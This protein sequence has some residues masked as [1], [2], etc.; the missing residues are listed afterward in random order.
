M[1]LSTVFFAGMPSESEKRKARGHRSGS[2]ASEE[3]G[4]GCCP[5]GVAS[6]VMDKSSPASWTVDLPHLSTF[7]TVA[8]NGSFTAT[9]VA[10]GIFRAAVSQRIAVLEAERRVS[11]FERRAGR[12]ALTEAPYLQLFKRNGYSPSNLVKAMTSSRST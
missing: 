7:V 9:A 8:E 4:G 2:V 6:T 10:I 11:L 3:R 1:T 5:D 12:I